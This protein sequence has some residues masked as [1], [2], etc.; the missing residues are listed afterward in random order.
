[1]TTL[2][3]D[4]QTGASRAPKATATVRATGRGQA[5]TLAI[6]W[7]HGRFDA[8]TFRRTNLVSSWQS[9]E[10]IASLEDFGTVLDSCLP[11]MNY[12]GT[13]VILLLAHEQFTHHTEPCPSFSESATRAYL[14]GLV[15]RHEKEYGPALSVTQSVASIR[16]DAQ[17]LIHFLPHTFYH[18][19]NSLLLARHL[20][21]SRII[22]AN[23]PLELELSGHFDGSRPALLLAAELGNSTA[24]IA[25]R[26]NGEILLSRATLGTWRDDPGR[27]AVEINRS[28][29]YAKQQH[30]ADIS[31]VILIGSSAEDAQSEIESKCGEGKSFVV[32]ETQPVSWLTAAAKLPLKHPVNLIAGYLRKKRR[33]HFL[34]RMILTSCWFVLTLLA[35]ETW[36]LENDWSAEQARLAALRSNEESMHR[37]YEELMARNAGAIRNETFIRQVVDERLPP[38]PDRFLAY[39]ASVIPREIQLNQFLVTFDSESKN[40][41]FRIEGRL[42]ADPETA[43]N[44]IN[45]IRRQLGKSPFRVRFT[46][47]VRRE[48]ELSLATEATVQHFNLE[49]GLFEF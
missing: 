44:T 25:C 11:A 23:V 32:Q 27:V 49:G 33:N 8:A 6:A 12:R 40:W 3:P 17:H 48:M 43:R 14:R 28:L 45:S 26:E 22:P 46:E 39:V 5:D 24:V 36:S 29:L 34:R 18:D 10:A 37:T 19:L 38:V 7:I 41:T 21:L 16:K 4:R 31:Q 30:A 20:D 13:D 35:F 1:M 15:E 47:S 9:D 42:E 2:A